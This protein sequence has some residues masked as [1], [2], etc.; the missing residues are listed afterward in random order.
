MRGVLSLVVVVKAFR[1]P[2]SLEINRRR[3]ASALGATSAPAQGFPRMTT[4]C[5][6]PQTITFI[7]Y[8]YYF[9]SSLLVVLVD[10]LR[11]C[12]IPAKCTGVV[13]H[14][15]ER[16]RY[17]CTSAVRHVHFRV[18]DKNTATLSECLRMLPSLLIVLTCTLRPLNSCLY[19]C[20]I[21]QR[22]GGS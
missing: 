21:P 3:D 19:N 13:S 9:L 16:A 17:R 20:L 5:S 18:Y 4:S 15:L 12:Y 8:C 6:T 10:S 11:T 22:T 1:I 2:R 14:S 7:E